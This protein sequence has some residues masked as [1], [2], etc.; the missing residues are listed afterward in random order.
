MGYNFDVVYRKDKDNQVAD[1][2][3]RREYPTTTEE[4]PA[5]KGFE[6][7]LLSMSEASEETQVKVKPK[8]TW[9]VKL[10]HP[11]VNTETSQNIS[12]LN[13]NEQTTF[14]ADTL[15]IA[16]LQRSCEDFNDMM[17]F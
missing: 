7:Y 13:D 17:L 1:A 10:Q 12:S 9:L 8:K 11:E 16:P 2:I 4:I 6:D 5:D 15:D 14:E 3:S